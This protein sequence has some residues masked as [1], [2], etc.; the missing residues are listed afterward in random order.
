MTE[1]D[2]W[3]VGGVI[4]LPPGDLPIRVGRVV[5][6]IENVS[7]AD[8]RSVCVAEQVQE[9]VAVADNGEI[10]FS[11]AIHEELEPSSHYAVRAHLDV[12]GTGDVTSGDYVST[13]SYP[14]RGDEKA[15]RLAVKK[16]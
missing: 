5:A 15:L 12:T 7:R 6:R 16:I 2:V 8:T 11:I 1:P 13:V 3:D 4:V 9:D 10:E 14:V